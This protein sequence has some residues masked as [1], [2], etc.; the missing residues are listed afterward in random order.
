[1]QTL[2]IGPEQRIHDP[3][4]PMKTTAHF[5]AFRVRIAT[6]AELSNEEQLFRNLKNAMVKLDVQ[7][8]RR[9]NVICA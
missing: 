9:S 3:A 1:M 6:R 5:L 8:Y 2:S 4:I 7:T